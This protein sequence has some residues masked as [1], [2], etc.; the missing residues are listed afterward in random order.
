MTNVTSNTILSSTSGLFTYVLS[1]LLL[2]EAFNLVKLLSILICITGAPPFQ[3]ACVCKVPSP[4]VKLAP[5]ALEA[6]IPLALH[7]VALL[8]STLYIPTLLTC[9]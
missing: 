1:C 3:I 6:S 7:L 4:W 2:A 9:A 5:H 8:A